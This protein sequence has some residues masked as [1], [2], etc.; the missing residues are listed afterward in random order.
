M[1]SVKAVMAVSQYYLIVLLILRETS[2]SLI[3]QSI[4]TELVK[5]WDV[6]ISSPEYIH[7]G[8][9][10]AGVSPEQHP[11]QHYLHRMEKMLRSTISYSQG[12]P[13]HLVF[14]SDQESVQ[15]ISRRVESAYAS[16]VM[17]RILLHNEIWKMK[18]YRIPK[19]RVEFV[20][21][22]AITDK[23]RDTVE[24]MKKHF[25]NYNEAYR[26][27]GKAEDIYPSI[28]FICR[29][30][31]QLGLLASSEYDKNLFYL[32]HFY[33]L[34]FPFDKFIVVDADIEFKYRVES[35]Y[36]VFDGFE[37]TQ[38]YSLGRDLSPFYRSMIYQYRSVQGCKPSHMSFFN[39]CICL[40]FNHLSSFFCVY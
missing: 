26:I 31:R 7:M 12:T 19:L 8:L 27:S 9:V 6:K 11:E 14:I 25:N 28:I 3:R 30:Q 16:M 10:M 5:P 17:G 37:E 21:L 24:H 39:L 32:A 22:S 20:D 13:L 35:L 4:F 38:M 15:V 33:H 23:Y 36:D 2:S 18:R 40:Y 34:V 29:K 1:S